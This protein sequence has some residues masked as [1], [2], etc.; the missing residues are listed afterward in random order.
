MKISRYARLVLALALCAC[1]DPLAVG[2]TNNPDRNRALGTP[3]DLESFLSKAYTVVHQ[4]TLGGAIVPGGGGND[5]LQPQLLVMGMESVSGLANFAMGP[6][7]A[8]PRNPIDNTVGSQGN[9]GNYRDFVVE[10]RAA[11]MSAPSLA[12][13]QALGTPGSPAPDA[14]APAFAPFVEGT[15]P[16]AIALAYDSGVVG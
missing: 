5:A 4:G 12:K 7:S 1:Q 3:A 16:G 10:H 14:P 8:L 2:N 11:F 9:L 6:R 13:L 15:A